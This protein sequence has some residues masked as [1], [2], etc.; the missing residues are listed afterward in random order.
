MNN[1]KGP[2]GCAGSGPGPAA[3]K[4]K[5]TL[6]QFDH[7]PTITMNPAYSMRPR[8]NQKV[9]DIFPPP[10]SIA[11]ASLRH[12]SGIPRFLVEMMHDDYAGWKVGMKIEFFRFQMKTVGPGPIY[13]VTWLNQYGKHRT[14]GGNMGRRFPEPNLLKNRMPG[15]SDYCPKVP[16]AN[17]API[18]RKTLSLKSRRPRTEMP[19]F[20]ILP[21]TLSKRGTKL[22]KRF[23]DPKRTADMPGPASYILPHGDFYLHGRHAAG[24]TMAGRFKDKSTFQGPSPAHYDVKP[25]NLCPYAPS[26]DVCRTTFGRKRP[27]C[28]RPY[29]LPE[30]NEFDSDCCI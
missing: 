12:P 22:G 11:R 25:G 14:V 4:L 26:A 3:Y 9:S 1:T 19:A 15:P 6:G 28:V 13:D 17:T 20:Y 21:D 24:P 7:D 5:S 23:D 8:I 10:S 16:M 29:V 18:M 30:D 2:K 27:D